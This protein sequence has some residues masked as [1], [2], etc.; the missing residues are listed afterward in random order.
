LLICGD[1]DPGGLLI[2]KTMRKNFEDLSDAIGW[3]PTNLVII[4]FGL[5]KDFIDQ[6][7]L[8][9]IDNLETSSGKQLDNPEH[10]DHDKDYV[11]DY[12]AEFGVRKC[13][14]NALVV[15]PDIGRQLCRDAILEHISLN[16]VERYERRL[17]RLRKQLKDALR[18]RLGLC[19]EISAGRG[20]S[21][22]QEMTQSID[23]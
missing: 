6:H 7:E 11:Q 3:S 9:W 8:T 19:A 14:A 4:R 10:A 22:S 17:K 15:Q 1:H 5:N 18:A 23:R 16:A 13:E 2:T 12:I 21:R 20:V